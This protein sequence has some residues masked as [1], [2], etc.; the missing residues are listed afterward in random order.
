M[1]EH[2]QKLTAK[3]A[4]RISN[5]RRTSLIINRPILLLD[6]IDAVVHKIYFPQNT[7]VIRFPAVITHISYKLW[8]VR[9]TKIEKKRWKFRINVFTIILRIIIL[10]DWHDE[11]DQMKNNQFG[12]K[13][14]R[15]TWK[16]IGILPLIIIYCNEFFFL[17]RKFRVYTQWLFNNIFKKFVLIFNARA[18]IMNIIPTFIKC[19][20][21]YLETR[22]S[23]YNNMIMPISLF[24]FNY[25]CIIHIICIMIWS[26]F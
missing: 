8:C 22:S 26:G 17:S 9:R 4:G 23:E 10:F 1:S 24:Y 16:G 18:Y 25:G 7:N 13:K 5:I 14:E 19:C 3:A 2:K 11:P 6:L 15:E 20:N 12:L 21:N